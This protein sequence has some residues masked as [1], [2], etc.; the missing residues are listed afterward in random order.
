MH[1]IDFGDTAWLLVS[2]A[3]VM[4]MTAPGLAYFYGGLVRRKNVLSTMM[5]SFF[6]LC[7]ISVQWVLWGYS[8]AFGPDVWHVIGNLSWLGLRGVGL[9]PNPDYAQ[10]IPHQLFMIYQMMFAV[11]T[12][13]LITGAFAERIKFS[14][15]AIFSLLW[16]TLVYD[17][18]A[19][20]VW[21]VGGWLRNLG[22]LDF[23]GGTVVHI[24]SGISALIF[25][26]A[27][28]RRN[29]Y[30]ARVPPP[31]NMTYTLAGAAMLWFGWFGFNAGSALGANG[32]A[33]TAFINTNT[34]AA[35]AALSWLGIEWVVNKKPTVLGGATGAVAGLVAITP[36]AGFVSPLASL[37][38]GV[39]VAAACYTAVSVVKQKLKYDDSLDAF[40]VHGVG[41]TIGALATGL[42][43]RKLVNPAGADGLLFGNPAQ[44]GIQA[45]AVAATVAYAAGVTFILVK[46]LDRV[47]GLRVKEEAEAIGL[48]NTQHKESAYTLID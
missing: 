1:S 43:A 15:F 20:W 44:L 10:T 48:D 27:I 23:A 12:P 36:A 32:L 4:L 38:I 39:I 45:V 24:S 19:H 11:I 33:V 9:A 47:M 30:P 25:A 7:L 31:H 16:T 34:A 37:C 40:G 22:A 5:Q 2:T 13:A 14:T 8:L 41:G 21:G 3:L 26:L 29:G 42:F 6:L 46:A 17:P 35:A 28:G 18:V